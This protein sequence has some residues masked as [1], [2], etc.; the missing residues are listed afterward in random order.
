M[1]IFFHIPKN[2]HNIEILDEDKAAKSAL[3]IIVYDVTAVE[4]DRYID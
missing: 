2:V 1:Q 4:Q 3:D